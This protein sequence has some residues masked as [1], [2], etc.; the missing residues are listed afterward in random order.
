MVGVGWMLRSSL[1][2][3]ESKRKAYGANADVSASFLDCFLSCAACHMEV[4]VASGQLVV[5]DSI[6]LCSTWR[7]K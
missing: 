4:G 2:Q 5:L 6:V 1:K 3:C 7:R